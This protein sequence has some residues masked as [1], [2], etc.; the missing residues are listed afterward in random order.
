MCSC[1][2]TLVQSNVLLDYIELMYYL[3]IYAIIVT[4]PRHRPII[5]RFDM[6]VAATEGL[7]PIL[8]R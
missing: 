5:P 3:V 4:L 7:K 1:T 6:W 8:L 2:V